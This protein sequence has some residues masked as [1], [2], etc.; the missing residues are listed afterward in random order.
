MKKLITTAFT[1]LLV[2]GLSAQTE[3][4]TILLGA[5]SNF[6]F[7]NLSLSD[8]EGEDKSDLPDMTSSVTEFSINGGY[9]I[10]DNLAIGLGINYTSSKVELE[11]ADDSE[12]SLLTYGLLVRY[13]VGESGLWGEGSY[14]IGTQDDG[15]D[16]IDI[17][18]IGIDV[19]YAWYLSDNISINPSLGYYIMNGEVD[20]IEMKM[21]GLAASVGIVIHL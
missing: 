10:I 5:D 8:I 13:Y 12:S 14:L 16:D 18:G 11:G 2:L 19:G 15:A 1:F 9:F 4:G 17:S 21:D 7:V 6:G 3:E 20:N